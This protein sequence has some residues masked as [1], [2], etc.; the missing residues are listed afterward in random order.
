MSQ[1]IGRTPKP[2]KLLPTIMVSLAA[3]A[4][5]FFIGKSMVHNGTAQKDPL[6]SAPK[7][8]LRATG[9]SG[10]STNGENKGTDSPES[11]P[12]TPESPAAA[13]NLIRALL[14][15]KQSR[16]RDLQFKLAALSL[17]ADTVAQMWVELKERSGFTDFS[18][19]NELTEAL[20]TRWA[21]IDPMAAIAA[22]KDLN[23]WQRYN[24]ISQI[25]R[26][27]AKSD[28]DSVLEW[29]DSESNTRHRQ[30]AMGAVLTE[31]GKK[32]RSRALE[33]Y[34]DA[35][36]KG[37]ITRDRWSDGNTMFYEWAKDA[38][39][40]ASAAA[41]KVLEKTKS[42]GPMSSA[43]TAWAREDTTAALEWLDS[44]LSGDVQL[45][46]LDSVIEAW[47]N[48]D[49]QAAA[50]HLLGLE[51]GQRW[52]SGVDEVVRNWAMRD[53]SEASKWIDSIGDPRRQSEARAALVQSG[54]WGGSDIEA[55]NYALP[56]LD[57][58]KIKD[59]LTNLTWNWA[60]RDPDG[61]MEW[62]EKNVDDDA[63]ID[64]MRFHSIQQTIWNNP[65]NAAGDLAKL[66]AGK[67]RQ[68][69][70]SEVAENWARQNLDAAREWA[71]NLP[72]GAERDLALSN[73]TGAWIAQDTEAATA[74][75]GEMEPGDLRDQMTS[76]LA[77][78]HAAEADMETAL[79]AARQIEDPH[80]RADTFEN[81]LQTWMWRDSKAA[82]E[83]IEASQE[84]DARTRWRLLTPR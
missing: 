69:A 61:M 65:G 71:N 26:V 83:Y 13:I 11:I 59:S 34:F 51:D 46:M 48:R 79:E 54:A 62:L 49:P 80:R 21:E 20:L 1:F 47:S 36:D 55:A 17:D 16:R 15:E 58:E 29:I 57:D 12:G 82:T 8:P 10:S 72:E 32:D 39:A 37:I 18:N 75:I 5:G 76:K 19:E 50:S 52:K 63:L 67:E 43:L 44:N 6:A 41:L 42:D 45:R 9:S 66:P 30:T 53:F 70:Y 40:A 24:G 56:Y 77:R 33:L 78:Y 28:P 60:R 7:K 73:V 81:A 22:T 74:W 68:Q 25:T 64:R 27:W 4:A 23:G 3:A 35:V 14:E 2:M 84:I 31:A 38:P